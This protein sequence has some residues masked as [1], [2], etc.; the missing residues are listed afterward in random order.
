MHSFDL[1]NHVQHTRSC[2]KSIVREFT[3]GNILERS[4]LIG[5]IGALHHVV[6]I[7]HLWHILCCCHLRLWIVLQRA[8]SGL[9]M[10]RLNL[11]RNLRPFVSSSRQSVRGLRSEFCLWC[12]PQISDSII[13]SAGRSPEVMLPRFQNSNRTG[14]CQAEP[15]HSWPKV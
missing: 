10:E 6:Y 4:L 13:L 15:I 2:L 11:T 8:V 7:G 3:W 1:D 5:N 12:W 14:T 9:L